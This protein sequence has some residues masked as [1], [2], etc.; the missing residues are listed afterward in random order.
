M[1]CH[2]VLQG[3]FPTQ[4]LNPGLLHS[5]QSLY[6][7]SHKGSPRILEWVAIPSPADLP[8]PGI[9][10]RSPALQPYLT[11]WAIR[12]A[13][14]WTSLKLWLQIC[15]VFLRTIFCLAGVFGSDLIKS[16]K[17]S[18]RKFTRM[19]S[20]STRKHICSQAHT[21]TRGF[22]DQLCREQPQ[23]A[24]G[25]LPIRRGPFFWP[26]RLTDEEQTTKLFHRSV[27]TSLLFCTKTYYAPAWQLADKGKNAQTSRRWK[28]L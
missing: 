7:Q 20:F 27:K 2:A 22:R 13:W 8:D 9:E 19:S 25:P 15:W 18:S 26:W 21:V 10:P 11:N 1:G 16:Q 12:E 4:G 14:V 5:R 28:P 17:V 23:H 3:I 6:Q 24:A